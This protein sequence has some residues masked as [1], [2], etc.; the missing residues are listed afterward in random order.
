[1]IVVY[2]GAVTIRIEGL[3]DMIKYCF[4]ILFVCFSGKLLYLE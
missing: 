1:M 4:F 2:D 3:I